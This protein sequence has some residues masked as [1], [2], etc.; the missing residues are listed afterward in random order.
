MRIILFCFALAFSF[1]ACKTTKETVVEETIENR[2]QAPEVETRGTGMGDRTLPNRPRR[3]E[4]DVD[5]LISQLGLNE[6]QEIEF[7]KVWDGNNA[8]MKALR[9]KAK[10][11]RMGMREG[12]MELREER[13]AGIKSVLTAE[14]MAKYQEIMAK[15]RRGRKRG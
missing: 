2:G 9:E 10:G 3:Q 5:Q 14:Q 6:E 8:K 7:L 15:R 1:T 4:I 12:M 13:M 11:D